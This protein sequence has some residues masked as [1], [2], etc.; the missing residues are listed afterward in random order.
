M[1]WVFF[2]S[3]QL[4]PQL[5]N[6]DPHSCTLPE[7]EENDRLDGKE[8]EHR[9]VGLQQVSGGKVEEEEAVEGQRHRDVVDD[10][11]V[12]VAAVRTVWQ[13]MIMLLVIF[14]L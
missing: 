3:L 6:N 11:D 14:C 12:E 5:L 10:S 2:S 13:K 8:L 4:L 1:W 7:G 9:V